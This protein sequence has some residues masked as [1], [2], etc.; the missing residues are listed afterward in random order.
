[1]LLAPT[2]HPPM[3]FFIVFYG[4]DWVATVPPTLALCREQYGDDSAIVFGWVLASHQVGAALVAFLG[5]VARD[6]FGSYDL[7][8]YALGRAVRGGGADGAGDPAQEEHRT[9]HP[10]TAAPPRPASAFLASRP[11]I[12]C[13]SMAISRSMP[14]IGLVKPG[15]VQARRPLRGAGAVH[16]RAAA[17]VQH[18]EVAD[19]AL[20]GA[21]VA[22]GRDH[23]VR[24][25]PGAVGQHHL[26]VLEGLDG[27]HGTTRPR[28]TASIRP[29]SWTGIAPSLT[30]EY[31]PVS[32]R[33][34]P[35]AA[36]SGTVTRHIRRP[37]PVDEPHRQPADQDARGLGGP[38][39][40]GAAHDVRGRADREP[41]PGGAA[42]HQVDG[43]LGAGVADADDED[44]LARVRAPGRG[45]RA[46]CTSSPVKSSR[47]GQSGTCG[48]WL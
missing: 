23:R 29:T 27:R 15:E 14:L 35:C 42:L 43:D 34:R 12:F 31:R 45:T 4:L 1:M 17:G 21:V 28:F 9:G 8:W 24:G 22:G 13:A 48:V 2:V 6:A 40:R 26:A 38:A 11:A 19:Q 18:A 25:D 5:G 39:G 47:P 20:Q 10:L 30:R 46:A 37:A 3:V 7:V 16:H 41:H 36:R 33:G 32:G 44:V